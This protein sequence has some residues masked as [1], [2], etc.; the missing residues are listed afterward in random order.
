MTTTRLLHAPRSPSSLGVA[1]RGR[2][3]VSDLGDSAYSA[4]LDGSA[5]KA[6]A[7]AQ[8]NLTG[9]AYAELPVW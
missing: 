5:R 9:I 2:M 4:Q 1:R 3:L 7:V 8:A 6:L